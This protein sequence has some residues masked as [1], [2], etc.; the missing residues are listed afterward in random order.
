MRIAPALIA[1]ALA[2]V[3]AGSAPAAA[4]RFAVV[5]CDDAARAV[6]QP[7]GTLYG[8]RLGFSWGTRPKKLVLSQNANYPFTSKLPIFIR[9][10]G[11]AFTIEIS[12]TWHQPAGMAWDNRGDAKPAIA[13]GVRVVPCPG[14]D[15]AAVWLAYPGGFY[16]AKPAC[17]PI[18][19]TIGAKRYPARVP[20]GRACP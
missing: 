6:A 20:L 19:I 16:V 1:L 5:D 2:G 10:G 14:G 13:H 4:P 11:R 7:S 12:P 3:A 9:G 15:N 17:L 18:V 8:A